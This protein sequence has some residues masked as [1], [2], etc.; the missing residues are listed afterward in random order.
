VW[1]REG[2]S[3]TKRQEGAE[4]AWE[5]EEAVLACKEGLFWSRSR[6]KEVGTFS[7]II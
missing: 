5:R 6:V 4:Q 1:E 2:N 7:P 3:A